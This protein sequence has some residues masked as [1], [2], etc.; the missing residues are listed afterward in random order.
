[1]EVRITPLVLL[2][3]ISTTIAHADDSAVST[4]GVL[5]SPNHPQSSDYTSVYP[6]T[7]T[8]VYRVRCPRHC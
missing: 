1:M 6:D 5:H 3:A 2:W 7:L 8:P 4:H